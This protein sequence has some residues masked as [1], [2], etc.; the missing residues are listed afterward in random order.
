MINEEVYDWYLTLKDTSNNALYCKFCSDFNVQLLCYEKQLAT[1]INRLVDN[2]RKLK[3]QRKNKKLD[4]LLSEDFIPPVT[5]IP[6]NTSIS[7]E[8]SKET[9]LISENKM[10]KKENKNLKR[11]LNR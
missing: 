2:I 9:I 7:S 3:K 5:N 8:V 1:K 11:N 10:L 6:N 4:L